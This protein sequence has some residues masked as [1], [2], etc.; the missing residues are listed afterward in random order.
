MLYPPSAEEAEELLA[1]AKREVTAKTDGGT[2]FVE[3]STVVM[4]GMRYPE[5]ILKK[6]GECARAGDRAVA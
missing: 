3:G 1:T 6:F 4:T 5:A 2:A